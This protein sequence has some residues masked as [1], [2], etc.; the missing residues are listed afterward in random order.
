MTVGGS[1]V[2]VIVGVCDGS[3]VAERNPVTVAVGVIVG[4]SVAV[5]VGLGG[6]GVGVRVRVGIRVGPT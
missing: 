2:K 6:N 3:G 4:V 5:K 1:G